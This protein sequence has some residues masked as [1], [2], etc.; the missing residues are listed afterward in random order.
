MGEKCRR[1]KIYRKSTKTYELQFKKDGAVIDITD[2]T[3]YFTIKES[4]EDDDNEAKLQKIVISHADAPS[5]IA[6]IEL[7]SSDTDIEKGNYY[8]SMD[9]K[10]NEGNEDVLFAGRILIEEPILKSRS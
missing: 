1:L 6:L 9:Y 3:I 8:Y 7:S 5:G 4:M 2:W 10:D